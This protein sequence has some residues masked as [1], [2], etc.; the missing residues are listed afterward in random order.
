MK[1]ETMLEPLDLIESGAEDL[2]L[3]DG[4]PKVQSPWMKGGFGK[5]VRAWRFSWFILDRQ[6]LQ[7]LSD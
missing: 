4:G 5:D 2:L 6:E 3:G 1:E 7:H